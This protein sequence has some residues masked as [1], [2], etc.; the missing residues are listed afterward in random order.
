MFAKTFLNKLRTNLCPIPNSFSSSCE[1]IVKPTNM[2]FTHL[3]AVHV[4]CSVF[5]CKVFKFYKKLL[6]NEL[7]ILVLGGGFFGVKIDNLKT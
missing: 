4:L 3:T 2:S 1:H 6:T 5:G 7:P